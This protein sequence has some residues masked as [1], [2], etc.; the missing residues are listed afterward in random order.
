[1]RT[2]QAHEPT[3]QAAGVLREARALIAEPERWC[4]N[5]LALDSSGHPTWPSSDTACRFCVMGAFFRVADQANICHS[6]QVEIE[7]FLVGSVHERNFWTV[8]A[9]NDDDDTE[10]ADVLALYDAAI[11]RAEGSE[12]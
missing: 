11:A 2:N 8:A 5:E 10:H 3:R 9:L 6:E 4:K 1:M 7:R 12:P